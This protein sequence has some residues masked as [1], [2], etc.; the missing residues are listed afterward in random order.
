MFGYSITVSAAT[1]PKDSIAVH[2][3]TTSTTVV[4]VERDIA[5]VPPALGRPTGTVARRR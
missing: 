5:P 2:T 3:R 1:P 4:R